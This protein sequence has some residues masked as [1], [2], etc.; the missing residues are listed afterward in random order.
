MDDNND[1]NIRRLLSVF[2]N[3]ISLLHNT[4]ERKDNENKNLQA[5]KRDRKMRRR[6]KENRE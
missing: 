6:E 2:S 1:K 3:Y 5:G 4:N